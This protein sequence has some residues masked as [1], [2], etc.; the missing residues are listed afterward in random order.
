MHI[1]PVYFVL[2]D[3]TILT[4]LAVCADALIFANRFQQE[5]SFDLKFVGSHSAIQTSIGLSLMRIEPLPSEIEPHAVITV[6]GMRG[7]DWQEKDPAIV[8]SVAWLKRINAHNHTLL[9]ICMGNLLAAQAGLLKHKRCTTHYVHYEDLQR[10]EPNAL[11]THNRV[12][13]EDDKLYSS[14]GITSG[15]DLTLRFI[16]KTVSAPCAAAVAQHMVVYQRKASQ[17]PEPSALLAYR[18]HLNTAIHRVQLALLNNPAYPWDQAQMAQVAC[19]SER[20]LTRLFKQETQI[21]PYRYLTHI[22][23]ALAQ[24][25]SQDKKISLDE[26]AYRVGFGSAQQLRRA[27][28]KWANETQL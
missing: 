27:K 2:L 15:L 10:L 20:H 1:I 3:Q 14:A 16:E 23:L 28:N 5:V 18:N 12:F 13:V 21:S 19:V 17:D 7:D 8:E 11:L 25:I 9:A 24:Q 26:L 4:D 22:R 6:V